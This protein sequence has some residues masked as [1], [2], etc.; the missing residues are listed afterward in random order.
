MQFDVRQR[1][2][3][4]EGVLTPLGKPYSSPPVARAAEFTGLLTQR[5]GGSNAFLRVTY[6]RF[7]Q[8]NDFFARVF[9]NLPT[10]D[11]QTPTEDPHYAGSLSFFGTPGG[12]HE[13]M[14]APEH[15]VNVTPVLR[16]LM[17]RG[18][19]REGGAITVQ[20]VAAPANEAFQKPDLVLELQKIELLITPIIV[21]QPPK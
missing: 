19:L 10:A 5:D 16:R 9:V 2:L 17:E 11:A 1:Y 3:V 6:A 15:L 4:A 20:L 12:M 13:Q 21:R 7:P 8:A 14:H 18:E